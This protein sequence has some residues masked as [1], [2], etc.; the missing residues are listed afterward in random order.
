MTIVT[1]GKI[2]SILILSGILIGIISRKP[3]APSPVPPVVPSVTALPQ[4]VSE[5]GPT[6]DVVAENGTFTP[7]VFQ[8]AHLGTLTVRISAID[9]EYV[10][11]FPALSMRQSIPQGQTVT[12]TLDGSPVGSEPFTC[13]EG[14]GGTVE[15]YKIPDRPDED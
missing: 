1:F 15:F 3:V 7:N 4:P 10:F 5:T 12:L 9:R 14:C 2:V 8:V 6:L 11:D 13:G